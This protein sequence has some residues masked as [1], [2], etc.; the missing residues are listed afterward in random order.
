[1]AA[2]TLLVGNPTAQSGRAR[3]LIDAAL[4]R[5]ADR[6]L[7]PELLPTRPTGTDAAVRE[8]LDAGDHARVIA[9][10]GDGTFSLVA[11]GLLAARRQVPMGLVP[12]GT[13]NDQARSF[14]LRPGAEG[15][16]E[17]VDVIV[18]GH[19]QPI[20]VGVVRR[21]D[22]GGAATDEATFFDSVGW[23]MHP[24]VLVQRNRDREVVGQIPLVRDLYRDEAVYAGAIL[25]RYVASWLEPTKF[26]ADVV[27]DGRPAR[28]T[29]L[30]DL[31]VNATAIYAGSWVLVPE[32]EPDDG[33]FELVPIAGRRD[34]FV[35][36]V[37]DLAAA[38]LLREQLDALGITTSGWLSGARFE[39][40]LDRPGRP[41]LACQV[42]GEEW[43]AGAR[44]AVE[45]RPRALPLI[46]RA[47]WVP[48][49][50]RR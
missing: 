25:N 24:E 10:G 3:E 18:A 11:R 46:T 12:A 17:S 2:D 44:F 6:G 14:G 41:A 21:L 33:R 40:A 16:A 34:W 30:T 48:P 7:R 35:K 13:A 45:V 43:V 23:G 28:L 32:G 9:L 27:V 8:A 37:H 1:V 15:L 42:D 22:E 20:D 19:V 4:R 31:I 38:P 39:L 36:A 49:W 50:R 26:D 47:G 5:L 29:G